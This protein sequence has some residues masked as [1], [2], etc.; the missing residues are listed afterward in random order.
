MTPTIDTTLANRLK[1][2]SGL[3]VTTQAIELVFPAAFANYQTAAAEGKSV[4]L[5]HNFL[6]PALQTLWNEYHKTGG[7]NFD[8]F[9]QQKLAAGGDP[10]LT[11]FFGKRESVQADL[12]SLKDFYQTGMNLRAAVQTSTGAIQTLTDQIAQA[13]VDLGNHSD[14]AVE[15][16]IQ[17]AAGVLF[18]RSVRETSIH[19]AAIAHATNAPVYKR[20]LTARIRLLQ[21]RLTAEQAKL[22]ELTKQLQAHVA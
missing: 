11:K 17:T 5:E 16:S 8:D 20:V 9:V 7:K 21:T 10:L 14:D 12:D 19:D 3:P 18:M 22:K 4:E 2:A 15:R 1:G 6:V 13:E